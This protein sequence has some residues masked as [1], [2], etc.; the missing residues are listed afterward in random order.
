MFLNIEEI[1]SL[2]IVQ[3]VFRQ[4][5]RI[6]ILKDLLTNYDDGRA[7]SYFCQT[8]ALLPADELQAL[9]NKLKNI[10]A[11]GELKAKSKLAKKL[12]TE[13]ASA[14]NIDLKLNKKAKK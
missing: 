13:T 14:L 3:F 12:I 4:K 5:I 8:C 9:H 2:G 1:K 6:N 10:D 11:D 7:K